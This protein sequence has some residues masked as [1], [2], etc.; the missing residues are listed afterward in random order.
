MEDLRYITCIDCGATIEV[1]V[2]AVY[3]GSA[4]CPSCGCFCHIAK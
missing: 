4:F 2:Y 3:G 1:F